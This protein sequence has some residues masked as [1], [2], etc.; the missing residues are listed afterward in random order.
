MRL[1][2]GDKQAI[3]RIA[4]E[5]LE[6]EAQQGVA[7]VEVRFSPH[8][9]SNTVKNSFCKTLSLND[10]QASTPKEAVKL[11][12]RGLSRGEKD[13]GIKARLLLCGLCGHPG[14]NS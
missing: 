10:P 12:L 6:D 11:V 3:E 4:Y 8:F 1:F 14:N 5:F 2:S 7:Y 13:F 9:L